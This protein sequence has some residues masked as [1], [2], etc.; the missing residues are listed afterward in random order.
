MERRMWLGTLT[1]ARDHLSMT[2]GIDGYRFE[3]A[4]WY[5]GVDLLALERRYGRAYMDTL[6]FHML[7]FEANKLVSLRPETVDLGDFARFHTPAFEALWQKIVNKVWAQWRYEHGLP[8]YP[9]PQFVSTAQP[10]E[11]TPV[12]MDHGPIK[13]L[14]FCGGG[15]DSLAAMK[16]LERAGIPFSSYAYAHSIYGPAKPQHHL[17]DRLLDHGVPSSRHRHW[18]YDSFVD[19]PL[20]NLRA[21]YGVRSV[22]AAETPSSLFGVLPVVLQHGYRY[23]TLAHERSANAGNLIWEETGEDVNHQWGKSLEAERLLNAY[24]QRELIGNVTYFSL[25]QPLYDVAIYNLLTDHLDAV[26]ATHSC[27]VRKPWCCRCPKCA[28]V[29]INYMA[30]L[31]VDLVDA[32][33]GVNLLD[34]DENQEHYRQMLGLAEHTPFECIGQ[35]PETRLA[36]ELCRRKGLT[37]RAMDLFV[38]DVPPVDVASILDTYLRVHDDE[39]DLPESMA[40]R[41]VPLMKGRAAVTRRRLGAAPAADAVGR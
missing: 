31:P 24:L 9:G 11:R 30:Y 40:A 17:I 33:F 12:T 6:Y 21:E 37:G 15:K 38:E 19:A 20:A 39:A 10:A 36:F 22:L 4:Y 35:I 7:A 34:L 41:V 27:N 3:T 18:V 2:Y 16:L 29:W 14:A 28:Y 5:A 13:V 26:P 8:H 25:L 32:M 1:R 23:I